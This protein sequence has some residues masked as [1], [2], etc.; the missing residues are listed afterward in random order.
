VSRAITDGRCRARKSG[1]PS[2]VGKTSSAS[3]AAD[4][5]RIRSSASAR[6]SKRLVQSLPLC[7]VGAAGGRPRRFGSDSCRASV[8][9]ATRASRD[10]FGGQ[11]EAG[12]NEFR[13]RCGAQDV[14]H[15][16][17]RMPQSS[18]LFLSKTA[19][20]RTKTLSTAA[21]RTRMTRSK[22]P[23]K[24][25]RSRSSSATSPPGAKTRRPSVVG[26][27]RSAVSGGVARQPSRHFCS[28]DR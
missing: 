5:Q 14:R 19:A 17:C 18:R 26:D 7:C 10:G 25:G 24:F 3:I 1:R 11:G 28:Y 20:G 9:A 23:T 27:Q 15:S 16:E 21:R 8:H 4:Q 22:S 12:T 2:L 6:S 13:G